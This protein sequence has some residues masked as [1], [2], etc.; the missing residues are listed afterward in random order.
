MRFTCS[1]IKFFSPEHFRVLLAVEMGSK[2]HEA[3]PVELIEKISNAK[4]N[5]QNVITDLLKQKF[6]KKIQDIDYEG[7][8]LTYTGYDNLALYALQKE[9]VLLGVGRKIGVGKESDVYLGISPEQKLVCIKIHRLGRVCFK[10]VKKNREYHQGRKYASWMYLSRLSAEREFSLMQAIHKTI[11]I[12]DPISRNRHI[13]VMR[14]LEHYTTLSKIPKSQN[15]F[16]L[17]LK[18]T[19]LTILEKIKELGY[20]HGDYNEFNIM[21]R[22]DYQQVK[23]IDFPQML[24]VTDRKAE[25]YYQR[26]KECIDLYFKN[27]Q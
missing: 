2:N 27:L 16:P 11:P 25:E 7:Y 20:V 8:A 17:Q 10:T 6:I 4:C 22:N 24:P 14:Y 9:G 26:D 3:V 23:I 13:V 21:I 15:A 18:Q 5:L 12:P 19:L 1:Q